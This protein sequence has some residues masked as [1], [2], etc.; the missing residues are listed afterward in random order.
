MRIALGIEYQGGAYRGWQRQ[1][2]VPSIQK[3][4]E[5]ALENML[6]H[7]VE[8][9]CA[10]RTDA[11]VSATGQ[12]IHFDTEVE[13]PLKAYERGMNTLMPHDIA[14]T[15][16][17]P[18]PDTFHARFSAYSRRYRYII[19][20]APLRPGILNSGLT[21]CYQPLDEGLMHDA[22]QCLVGEHDFTSFRASLCQSKSPVRRVK[23][24]SVVRYG[25]HII[26]DI[27]ANAFLHHMVRN[28]V[29]SLMLVGQALEP[30]A[31]I[32]QLLNMKDRTKAAATAKPNGLY[33]VKVLYPDEF[34]I[35]ELPI[36]PLFLS[37]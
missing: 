36:G 28:I 30:S 34:D 4:V 16:A 3:N 35:P 32:T 20:N 14:V 2:D 10:G 13:R 17:K 19:Y 12:V 27:Q 15:W 29:G 24:I 6:R 5:A 25:R 31:W 23:D 7:K 1:S 8:I 22:A 9:T 33:L 11:G 21:H 37:D 18:V 26:V